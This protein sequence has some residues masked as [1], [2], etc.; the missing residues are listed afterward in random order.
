MEQ[1]RGVE[2][3]DAAEGSVGGYAQLMD[4]DG[5]PLTTTGAPFLGVS[6][7]HEDRLRPATIDRGRAP[8][9]LGEVAIDRGTAEDYGFAVG[10][11][12]TVLLAD[13]SQPEVEIVGIF[14]FGEAN[15]LLGARLTAFDADVAGAV[16]GAGDEVDS[17]DVV[18]APSVDPA[19]LSDRIQDVLPEGVESVTGT[20]VAGEANDAVGGF[21]DAFRNVLLG[22]AAVALFVSAFFINNTFSIVV[23]QRTRELALLRALGA[24]RTQITRSVVGEALV[25]GLVASIIGIG[26]GLLI[27][28]LLQAIFEAA[29]FGLPAQA[30]LLEPR[31]LAAA[32]VVGLGVT[33]VASLAPAR[34]ASAVAPIEGMREG[35]VRDR[36]SRTRRAGVG[37]ALTLTG[38]VLIA[39]GLWVAAETSAMIALLGIGALGV[40]IGVAQLSPVVAVPVAG[41]L[42]RPIAPIFRVAGRLAHANA[43]RNPDRTARTSS[44]L[45]IGLALVTTVFIVGHSMK[46]TFAASIE[47]SVGADYILSTEGFVGFSP[48][49]TESLDALPEIGA[50]SGVRMGEF[51][52][53]G[54]QRQLVAADASVAEVL[55]DIDVQSGRL[56]DLGDHSIFVHEDPAGDLGLAVGDQVTV[57]F[58]VGGPQELSVAGIYADA[59]Y[60]GNYFIDLDLFTRSY[61]TSKLDLLAFARLADGVDPDEGR[62]AIEGVLADQPQVKLDDRAGYQADQEA[63][64]DSILIAING[65]LGLALLIA[66][67][68]IAN[69][70]ALSVLERTREIG[71]LRAVGMRR[72]QTLEMVLAESVMV[73]VFGAVLGVVLG[74]VFGVALASAMPPSVITTV[75]IPVGTIALIVLIAAACGVV[76]GFLPARRAARLDVL[77]AIASE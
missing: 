25:V 53:E 28:M 42:G 59:A 54:E 58:A 32:A 73:A 45:M 62:A 19:A 10:D 23:G 77:R 75:A 35:V 22:F 46:Q 30:L 12:T 27:A 1:V 29:G 20:Q 11:H 47:D 69:T 52:F 15:N 57:E 41:T 61:P 18:A 63:Q 6:W 21:M 24:S 48:T 26:F 8:D 74:T 49:I 5:E 17:I 40:F 34:Q 4:L 76:A 71:L 66:L 56:A 33:L 64:F 50:I 55:V 9:G 31:T 72:R 14:T 36:W 2:G 60:V 38:A 67:L 44:A 16:F 13:G 70:L 65:L 43:V 39:V 7:G 3:V 37:A 51:L 68:G